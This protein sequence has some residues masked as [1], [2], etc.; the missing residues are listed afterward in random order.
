MHKYDE[1]YLTFFLNSKR[2]KKE[3]IW[4]AKFV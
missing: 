4:N 3:E 1:K 2:E